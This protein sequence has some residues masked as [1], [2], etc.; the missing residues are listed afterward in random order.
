MRNAVILS[1]QN[2]MT[3]F[4]CL[5]RWNDFSLCWCICDPKWE[6][7]GFPNKDS[8]TKMLL[9]L[10][11]DCRKSVNAKCNNF[12]I[13]LPQSHEFGLCSSLHLSLVY[14]LV[15]KCNNFFYMSS[16]TESVWSVVMYLRARVGIKSVSKQRLWCKNFTLCVICDQELESNVSEQRLRNKMYYYIFRCNCSQQSTQNVITFFICLPPSKEFGLC[17][18]ICGLALKSKEFFLK[19][20]KKTTKVRY[21]DTKIYYILRCNCSKLVNAK[22]NNFF[23][24]PSRSNDFGLRW[25]I[26][27][28]EMESK[29]FPNRDCDTKNY[30]LRCDCSKCVNAKYN[31]FSICLS[32]SNDFGL[33]RYICDQELES[34]E[35]LN[36]DWETKCIIAFCV[37]IAVNFWHKM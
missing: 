32:R 17:W 2:V 13:C 28:Q 14:A 12:F 3:F 5:P 6:S 37:A 34:K 19:K 26:C 4:I 33:C 8:D 9:H 25:C 35:F 11:C 29:E 10:R 22:C 30:I 27:D 20:K 7:K 36:N 23:I 16:T 31:N 18:Y 1:K 15:A 21:N 24:W